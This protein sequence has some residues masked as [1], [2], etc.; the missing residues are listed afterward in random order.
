VDEPM[1]S[2]AKARIDDGSTLG[3][4]L[5]RSAGVGHCSRVGPSGPPASRRS[6]FEEGDDAMPLKVGSRWRSSAGVELVVVRPPTAEVGLECGGEPMEPLQA[7]TPPASPPVSAAGD[8]D[9][10]LGKRYV[11]QTFGIEVL[12]T[13]AGTGPLSVSG[14]PMVIKDAAP[15]PSSD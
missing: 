2:L 10:R 14:E 13:K 6:S 9:I 5:H 11:N 1:R 3:R 7:S 12:C 8:L 4:G 15:L